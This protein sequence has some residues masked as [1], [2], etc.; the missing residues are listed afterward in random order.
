MNRRQLIR[1]SLMSALAQACLLDAQAKPLKQREGSPKKGIVIGDK[2]PNHKRILSALQCAWFYNWSGKRPDH[3]PSDIEYVP[4]I[5][6]YRGDPK[7]VEKVEQDVRKEN[8]GVL[9]GF[10]E[11]DRSD[12]SSMTVEEAIAAWPVLEKTG[13][14]LG[15]PACVNADKNWMREFMK[16]VK[17][18]KLRVDFVCVHMFPGADP[19]FFLKRLETIY[20][21]YKKPIWITEFCVVDPSVPHGKAKDRI[22]AKDVIKFMKDVLPKLDKLEYVERYAWFPAKISNERNGISALWDEKGK[23]TALGEIYRDH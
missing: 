10:H 14:R 18:R 4:M 2:E 22:E 9:L 21:L 5:W 17:Q 19:D 12:L 7:A 6:K 15:S 11:P 1:T 20:K 13:M 8:S 23:L 16:E 3:A